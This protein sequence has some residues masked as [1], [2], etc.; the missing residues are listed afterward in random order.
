MQLTVILLR[1]LDGFLDHFFGIP[2]RTVI[3]IKLD[4]PRLEY[5]IMSSSLFPSDVFILEY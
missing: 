4:L 2:L 1:I 5:D 3:G